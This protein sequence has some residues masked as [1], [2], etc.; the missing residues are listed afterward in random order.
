MPDKFAYK[1]P[2]LSFEERVD[3]LVAR[4]TLEELLFDLHSARAAQRI[5]AGLIVS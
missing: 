1:N 4:M 2:D 5:D 3:D